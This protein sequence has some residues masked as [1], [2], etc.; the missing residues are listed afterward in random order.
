M[1]TTVRLGTTLLSSFHAN[2]SS[3]HASSRWVVAQAVH[4]EACAVATM[5]AHFKGATTVAWASRTKANSATLA[6]TAIEDATSAATLGQEL[7]ANSVEALAR[8]AATFVGCR[9]RCSGQ[10]HHPC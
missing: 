1:A 6:Q 7:A 9:H 5:G 4:S 8:V 10:R 3:A 2:L